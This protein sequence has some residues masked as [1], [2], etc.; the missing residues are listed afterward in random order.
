MFVF[1]RAM[2]GIMPG[3]GTDVSP[4]AEPRGGC[5]KQ[6][7]ESARR[8]WSGLFQKN[9]VAGHSLMGEVCS[10]RSAACYSNRCLEYAWHDG[11]MRIE[12][13][14]GYQET[15]NEPLYFLR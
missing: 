10:G 6:Q 11:A 14:V 13:R 8:R 15:L 12:I 7:K 9:R 4:F 2:L 5:R 1:Y 3:C